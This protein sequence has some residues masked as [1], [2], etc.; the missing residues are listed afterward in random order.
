MNFTYYVFDY[1]RTFYEPLPQLKKRETKCDVAGSFYELPACGL[2]QKFTAIRLKGKNTESPQISLIV[3]GE[4]K[5][6]KQSI[7][8]GNELPY[9]PPLSQ[10]AEE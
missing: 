6:L 7:S 4:T 10:Y 3:G 9:L 2:H 8:Y 1:F 5:Q